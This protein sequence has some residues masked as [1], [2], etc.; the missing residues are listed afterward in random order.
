LS[1]D[2][3]AIGRRCEHTKRRGGEE[4]SEQEEWKTAKLPVLYSKAQKALAECQKVDECLEWKNKMNAL[5]S[6]ARQTNDTSLLDYANE[7]RNRA[8]NRMGEILTET[9]PTPG[10]RTDLGR[11]ASQ[12]RISIAKKAGISEHERKTA[13]RIHAMP[14]D[15]FERRVKDPSLGQRVKPHRDEFVKWVGIVDGLATLPG[16]G[17]KVLAEREP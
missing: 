11:T 12:G 7:I 1:E 6:Y 5:A 8:R 4:V 15:E 17:L 3:E 13:M 16:C 9:E 10:A 14:R 2:R